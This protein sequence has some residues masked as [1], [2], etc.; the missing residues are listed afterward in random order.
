MDVRLD[1]VVLRAL[2]ND[3]ERRYQR[4]SEVRTGVEAAAGGA[5]QDEA[6]SGYRS[7]WRVRWFL[8]SPE[9]AAVY[10]NMTSGEKLFDFL[11]PGGRCRDVDSG[12]GAHG[13]GGAGMGG[14]PGLPHL[15][16]SEGF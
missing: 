13:F 12:A 7:D 15:A 6:A 11:D 4:A 5:P 16:R 1:A 9:A 8:T 14:R 10:R 2:E 3:P